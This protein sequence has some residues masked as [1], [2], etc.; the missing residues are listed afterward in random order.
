M[1]A[2]YRIA[3]GVT[4]DPSGAK[5][6]GT[7]ARNAVA[8]IGKQ[9]EA[10]APK[11]QA[12][13]TALGK[14]KEA[15]NNNTTKLDDIAAYGREMDRLQARF[16]PMFAVMQRHRQALTDIANAE[17]VGAISA[18]TAIEARI[19]ETRAMQE[20]AGAAE[21]LA[22]RQ[23]QQAQSIVEARTI[24]PNRGADIEAYLKEMDR[25]QAR[26]DPMFALM[27]R[28]R[29][30]LLDINEAERVGAISASTAI[31]ARIR[32][33][34]AMEEQAGAAERL[35]AR[36][37][38]SAQSIVQ[39]QMIQPDRSADITAFMDE[40][41]RL[42][43]AYNPRYAALTT[44]RKTI[45]DIRQANRV[46]AISHDE[47]TAAISRERQAT[48]GLIQS[49]KGIAGSKGLRPDQQA[50][51]FTQGV[52][53]V[54][55]LA[56]GMPISQVILQQGPQAM[57][58]YGSMG[59]AAKAAMAAITPLRVGIA[60]TTA[61][62]VLG[63]MAWNDYLGSIKEVETAASGI[64]RATAGSAASMEAAAQNGAAAA[65]ISVASARTMEAQFL[66]TGRIASENFEQLIAISK[67]FGATIGVS[68]DEAGAALAEM[69]AD[70]SKAIDTLYRQYGLIDAATAE[71][72]RRLTAQNRLTEAQ[73]VLLAAL[74]GR[75]A[76]A[77]E[78]TTAL[79][80]AWNSVSKAASDAYD[81]MGKSIDRAL[82]GP[83]PAD[84]LSEATELYA[85]ALRQQQKSKG[86][87]FGDGS[88][89]SEVE[90]RR[91][92]LERLRQE[93][94][95]RRGNEARDREQEKRR[96]AARGALDTA[97]AS[98]ATAAAR[99]RRDLEDSLVKAQSGLDAPGL[100]D[101]Q[102]ADI[103]ATID[104]KKRALETLIPAQE[105]ANQ[106]AA[107][108]IRIQTERNPIVL[109]GLM[110]DRERLQ[111]A[112]EEIT[113]AE[114]S[115]RIAAAR[116]RVIQETL[117]A[118]RLQS[119]ELVEEVEARRRLNDQV[120][121]GNITAS[122]AEALLRTEI[123]LRPL[124]AAAA[125][126][127]GEEQ[128]KLAEALAAAK[129]AAA[130]SELEQRRA[131]AIDVIRG[132]DDD[133]ERLRLEKTLVGASTAEREKAL[134]VLEAEQMI[135][136][137]GYS[138]LSAEA[139][140]IR[141]NARE[142][143][144][145]TIEVEKATAAWQMFQSAGETAIDNVF[146]SLLKGDF[147][148][149]LNGLLGDV[150]KFFQELGTNSIKNM[151][152][153]GDRPE[154]SDVLGRFLKGAPVAANQ[155]TPK[156]SGFESYAAPLI[157]VTRE[158]L[159]NISSYAKAIQSIE[160]S[161][162]YGALGPITRSGDRA[163]GAYQM[164]G[165]N[166]GPW[167]EAALGRRLSTSQFLG[168][169]SAQDAIF[170]HRFGGY[171]D[172]YGPS[173]AAQAW[174]GGPGSVGKG[175]RG[176]DVL[177]TTG[178]AYVDKFNE[179]LG[180]ANGNLDK[181]ATTGQ[182]ASTTVGSLAGAS[183]SA[184]KGLGGF[185][186]GLGQAGQNLA[187]WFPPAPSGGGGGGG[188]FGSLLT[189]FLPNFVPNGAQ[190]NWA[191]N[192]PGKGLFDVGGYTGNGGRSD[193]AGF[194]H[195][196]EY[197]V[198][199]SVVAQPG[200]RRMLDGLNS[201]RGYDKGGFVAKIGAPASVYP[202]Q[203]QSRMASTANDRAGSGKSEINVYVDNPRGD[204][205]IEDAVDRGVAKGLRAYDKNL[206]ARFEQ[207]K[208]RPYVRGQ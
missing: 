177:G 194:V 44:Y 32:E 108:D 104:A 85:A 129:D 37:K 96:A 140:Q 6:G 111:L 2:A 17:K 175:G 95:E 166:I 141:R 142:I 162:N 65:G 74:P 154:L 155:N 171:V 180:N 57:Q 176:A 116:N 83:S 50:N 9:A 11:V 75:L 160:S 130:A 91:A 26:F 173:G 151:L 181:L 79:G 40:R 193:I 188:L 189:A 99:A 29:K 92:E 128:K 191:V 77:S 12:V 165:N 94:M 62:V 36:R 147:K 69:F 184:V 48:L 58:I 179:A 47:M 42:R 76:N 78:A 56:L 4:V 68:A 172:K 138:A 206:P 54:Q 66:R 159:G 149:A 49:R 112:G 19:R 202:S 80:R 135:R 136:A 131:G 143:A 156:A 25:L 38:Q 110:A 60:G 45:E 18:S 197:V 72:A 43:Q 170:N 200:V 100:L 7:E 192:N 55:S 109:A 195:G 123:Q 73:Q 205:D 21:R 30:A 52:D 125:A 33:T 114:A 41:D 157:P 126:A 127:Q 71:Y 137:R 150:G 201:G 124:A 118:S 174:F 34:R 14:L 51:L 115:S 93:D 134:A 16:D 84:A 39:S 28:H 190:A 31:D 15:A 169:K 152:L 186:E 168:D 146:S 3:I 164:M 204:R 117:A 13:T 139:E 1:T 148:G 88:F 113:T 161:G 121:A 196:Q 81:W 198:K 86:T 183:S 153:G 23:K 98:P 97:N 87:I 158:P 185:G 82:S 102:R 120:A 187:N 167:S 103:T 70:P 90:E 5:S 22:A 20:Q 63:A 182:N 67:N 107:L 163:Y 203:G 27:E 46:G 35:A 101:S 89:D 178:N 106:L 133:L 10:V 132:Q 24:T 105:R 64:G 61:A 122:Q 119:A 53:T 208:K 59:N 8:A 199:A 144:N 207:I 145:Q